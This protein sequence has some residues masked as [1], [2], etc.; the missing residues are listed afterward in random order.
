[1]TYE[2]IKRVYGEYS[3]S[4]SLVFRWHNE[5]L[6]DREEVENE[7]RM[8]RPSISRTD[9]NMERMSNGSNDQ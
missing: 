6:K 9:D 4:R 2:K 5:F 8:G 3:L 7:L 1:M